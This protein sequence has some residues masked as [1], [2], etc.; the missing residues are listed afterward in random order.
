MAMTDPISDYL[1]R[2]RNAARANHKYVDVPAS[3][4]KA[5]ISKVLL[6]GGFLGA[7]KYIE[8]N[9]Q[10]VLRLYIRYTKDNA[11]VISGMKR[12]S[13]PSRRV[14]R[15]GKRLPRVLGGYGMAIVSTSQGILPDV[16]CRKRGIGGEILC[17]I[18]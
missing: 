7:V 14:Y 17:E 11:S 15:P 18:W 9:R 4:V 16:E 2:L 10:G 12:V 13:K 8:D 3:R 6:D 5:E 1:T